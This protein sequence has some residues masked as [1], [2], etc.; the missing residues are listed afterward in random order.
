MEINSPCVCSYL[1]YIFFL[2]VIDCYEYKLQSKNLIRIVYQVSEPLRIQE[3]PL[4]WLCA[5]PMNRHF[6]RKRAFVWRTK[7]WRS[8][9]RYEPPR[10]GS[11]ADFDHIARLA[12]H[13]F[14]AP[15]AAVILSSAPAN[16][17][18]RDVTALAIAQTPRDVSFLPHRYPH[19]SV[20]SSS[21][22]D[23]TRDPRFADNPFVTGE[24]HLRFYAGAPLVTHD[25]HVLGR[26]C[27]D[28]IRSRA[29]PSR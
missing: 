16:R 15:I 6:H 5:L 26:V 27:I 29:H 20:M 10:G 2:G 28:R 4:S 7:G 18:S 19:Q 13:L 1:R 11:E 21:F 9:A 22:E 25:D 17:P 24:P 8:L 23:T 14:N 3:G 12:A